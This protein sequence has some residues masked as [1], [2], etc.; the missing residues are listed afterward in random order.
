MGNEDTVKKSY[1]FINTFTLKLMAI[2]FMTVDHAA[3]VIGTKPVSGRLYYSSLI[4]Q[5]A[6]NTMRCLGRLAFPIYC[7]LIVE[8][9]FFTRSVKKYVLR[10]TIFAFISQIPFSLAIM[11]EPFYFSDL[12]TLFTLAIGLIC[13]ALIDNTITN[14][15]MPYPI[16][17]IIISI[18]STLSI[19]AS[20]DYSIYGILLILIFYVFRE[21]PVKIFATMTL[22][23]LLLQPP[24]QLY[25]LFAL[26]PI[27]LYNGKKGPSMKYVFYIYYPLHLTLLYFI[28]MQLSN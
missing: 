19:V 24:T 12:N 3:V 1:K 14:H 10:L 18:L 27:L 28:Y 8:G 26:I 5:N 20:T 25:S 23:C 16:C 17:F 2:I 13:V 4:S 6:Y 22:D 21:Q 11:K 9:F 7:Y 15:A